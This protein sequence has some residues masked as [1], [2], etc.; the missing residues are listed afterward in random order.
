MRIRKLEINNLRVLEN[1][2][3]D[4]DPQLNL[5][6]GVNGVG[7]STVLEALRICSSR[8]LPHI[9][10]SRTKAMSFSIDDIRSGF[11]FLDVEVSFEH[12]RQEFRYTRREWS[13]RFAVDDQENIEKLKRKIL[14]TDRLR[15]RP[16]NLLRELDESLDVS[17]TD[18]FEPSLKDLKKHASASRIASNCIFFSTSRSIVSDASAKK[19]KTAGGEAA[20]YAEALSSRSL[21]LGQFANWM[22]AQKQLAG[23]LP[24]SARHLEVLERVVSRFLPD[25]Q[26]LRPNDDKKNPRL[27]IDK[28]GTTLNVRQLSDGE[29]GIL[30]LVLDIARRLS[31]ANPTL[32]D[33]LG[34]GE[35]IILIDEIDLHLHPKWQRQIL[36][37]LMAVFPKCQFI[38]TT[39]SPQVIGEVEHDRI[40]IIANGQV[41]SP[42]HSFGVDSSRVLDEIMEAESR[43]QEVQD[44]LARLSHAI[45]DEQ[46]ENARQLLGDLVALVGEDDTEV[47]RVRTLLEFMEDSE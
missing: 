29:R 15:D 39:H 25:Y 2:E 33:P 1:A 30:A 36:K 41:Y 10:K 13:E 46:F 38:A 6:V 17:D 21:Y 3:F 47:I 32:D 23:E 20:A 4:F 11:P 16:R 34:D 28:S 35:A 31:Q 22:Q 37:N 12:N 26:S 18:S 7:K 24:L 14:D 5:I 45:G 40:W 44:L 43:T 27:L 42:T 9:T 19:S 8:I